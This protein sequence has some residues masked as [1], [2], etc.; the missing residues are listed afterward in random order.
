MSLLI[1]VFNFL[2]ANGET[3]G[4]DNGNGGDGLNPLIFIP[5]ALMLL[6]IVILPRFA[7]R[8]KGKNINDMRSTVRVGDE[9]MCTSGII[10][11][12]LEIVEHPGGEKSF[13]VE[14]GC[15]G[16]KSTMQI[17][18]RALFENRTRMKELKEE[19]ARQAEIDKINKENKLLKKQ[20][21]EQSTDS[22]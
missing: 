5:I 21:S 22:N 13:F 12:V 11:K 4:N 2:L 19:A 10:G 18:C 9:I 8:K 15:E 6:A 7:M 20:D 1:S 16:S 3:S 17:D 14:S